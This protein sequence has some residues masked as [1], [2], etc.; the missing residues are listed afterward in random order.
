[1]E[2]KQTLG[3]AAKNRDCRMIA[4]KHTFFFGLLYL[5]YLAMLGQE[6]I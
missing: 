5:F 6:T 1:M 2:K 3:S 4:N